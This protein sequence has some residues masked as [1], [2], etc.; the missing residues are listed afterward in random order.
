MPECY[1][2]GQ[3]ANTKRTIYI[4]GLGSQEVDVCDDCAGAIDD[5]LLTPDPYDPY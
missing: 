1:Y 5:H 3:P 2:C 4:E